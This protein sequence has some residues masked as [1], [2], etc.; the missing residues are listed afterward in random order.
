[1]K[2]KVLSDF[3]QKCFK[4]TE[5]HSLAVC[6]SLWGEKQFLLIFHPFYWFDQKQLFKQIQIFLRIL[7][8]SNML[9]KTNFL[10]ISVLV[11]EIVTFLTKKRGSLWILPKLLQN[12][13]KAY[14]SCMWLTLG[15]K[16]VLL[17]FLPFYW[18]DQKQLFKQIQIFLRIFPFANLLKKTKILSISVLLSEIVT[19]W[20]KREVLSEFPLKCFKKIYIYSLAECGS[21]WGEKQFL[22]IFVPLHWFDQK[23]LFKQIQIFLRIFSFSNMLRKT[24]FLSIS[25][26]LSEIVTFLIEKRS[27]LWLFPKMLQNNRKS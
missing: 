14:F 5:K 25:K 1:M 15:R 8:S 7:P 27:S 21:H 2:I 11:S 9:R 26:R 24:N 17:I 3:S 6:G 13:R 10:T 20:L 22:L 18:F 16:T 4:I 19:F 23:Q 12:N